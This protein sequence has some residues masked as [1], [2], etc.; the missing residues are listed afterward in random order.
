MR[1]ITA[2]LVELHRFETVLVDMRQIAAAQANRLGVS[3]DK[4]GRAMGL[5]KARAQQLVQGSRPLP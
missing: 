5:T 1:A 2:V 3:Y 4:L